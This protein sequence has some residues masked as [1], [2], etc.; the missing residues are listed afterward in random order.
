M[1]LRDEREVRI[2][3]TRTTDARA[4][5]ELF[6]RLTEEDVRSRFFQKLTSSRTRSHSTCAA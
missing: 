6:F 1:R 4:M 5:Q 3:P 2:R